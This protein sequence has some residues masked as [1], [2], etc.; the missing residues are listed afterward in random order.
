MKP[1]PT[2]ATIT[3]ERVRAL[4]LELAEDNPV[5]C[6]GLFAV[7][8]LEA[9]TD[10]DTACVSIGDTPPR[11]LVNLDFVR[12]HCLTQE[13]VQAILLHEYLHVLLRH[14]SALEFT[15]LVNVAADIVI[16]AVIHRNAG[17]LFSGFMASYYANARGI[18]RLLRPPTPDEGAAWDACRTSLRAY[19]GQPHPLVAEL[20]RELTASLPPGAPPATAQEAV[21]LLGL[22]FCAYAGTSVLADVIETFNELQDVPWANFLRSLLG[23]HRALQ[24]SGACGGRPGVPPHILGPTPG[25]LRRAT[26]GGPLRNLMPDPSPGLVTDAWT[27]AVR[28]MLREVLRPDRAGAPRDAEPALLPFL[29]PGDRRGAVV[30]TWSPLLPFSTWADAGRPKHASVPV[31]LDVSGSMFEDLPALVQVIHELGPNVRRPLRAFST[32]VCDA[33]VE[34]GRL[35]TRTT[36]GTDI[37]CVL[38]ELARTKPATALLFT[39]G[40]VTSGRLRLPPLQT[41]VTVFLPHGRILMMP[42]VPPDWTVRHLPRADAPHG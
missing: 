13:H 14:T 18:L 42:R 36:G 39:D 9:S 25:Q 30:S 32:R 22:W 17:P 40:D 28:R 29:A 41:K 1:D 3:V 34:R 21:R 16:N 31:Y 11:L 37:Q 7:A 20:A 4:G 8:Q 38:D 12:R 5:G 10:V 15:P 26:A 33:R 19:G 6:R 2:I 24:D 23:D 27:R 35:A